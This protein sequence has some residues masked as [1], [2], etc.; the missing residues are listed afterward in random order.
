MS[1][2]LSISSIVILNA[3]SVFGRI[4]PGFLP[5]KVWTFQHDGDMHNHVSYSDST[6][7][8]PGKSSAALLCYSAFFDFFSGCYISLTPALVAEVSPPSDIGH[9]TGI[10]YFCI[11][12]GVLASSPIASAIVEASEEWLKQVE[13]LEYKLN[14]LLHMLIRPKR[15]SLAQ[16]FHLDTSQ[17]LS[18]HIS[19]MADPK[20]QK[21]QK[22][23][24]LSKKAH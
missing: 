4:L 13:R 6:V 5:D 21:D 23:D 17:A 19:P 9:R 3:V 15:S 11:S 18:A 10:L 16:G 14:T 2:D 7:W 20:I 24:I 1:W 8:L 12:V 22:G